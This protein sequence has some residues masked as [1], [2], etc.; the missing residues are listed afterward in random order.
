MRLAELLTYVVGDV[1]VFERS[2]NSEEVFNDLYRGSHE[3]VPKELLKREV[4]WVG[5]ARARRID[6]CLVRE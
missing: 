5:G 3:K 1:N 2:D 6:I 4:H